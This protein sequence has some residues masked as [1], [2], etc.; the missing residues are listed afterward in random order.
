M[1]FTQR[2]IRVQAVDCILSWMELFGFKK[3]ANEEVPKSS[4]LSFGCRKTSF[5]GFKCFV[6][7]GGW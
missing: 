2:S 1:Y 6:G 3:A 7:V 5:N 4:I